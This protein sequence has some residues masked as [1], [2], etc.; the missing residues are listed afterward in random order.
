MTQMLTT[1]RM[2]ARRQPSTGLHPGML[3]PTPDGTSLS[4]MT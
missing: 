1:H 2:G 3:M 4:V